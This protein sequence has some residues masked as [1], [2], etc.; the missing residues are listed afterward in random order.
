LAHTISNVRLVVGAHHLSSISGR[1]SARPLSSSR[2]LARRERFGDDR[3][4]RSGGVGDVA[5]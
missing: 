2:R 5:G 1:P 3:I 4:L